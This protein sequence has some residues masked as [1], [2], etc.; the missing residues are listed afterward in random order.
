MLQ[1]VSIPL[2]GNSFGKGKKN[3]I[4]ELR[5][6]SF[7]PLTGKQF[8]KVLE[9]GTLMR[10]RNRFHPLTGKQFRK[11]VMQLNTLVQGFH[12]L[13]GKQFRKAVCLW[14]LGIETLFPSPY[15]EIVSESCPAVA[16][17]FFDIADCFHPLTGK[18]FRKESSE[19]ALRREGFKGQIDGTPYLS[20]E[21]LQQKGIFVASNPYPDWH[22]R[23]P[24]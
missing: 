9:K 17:T 10:K 14:F 23:E 5:L 4:C 2:R 8:R 15:G 11:V 22:R 3:Q 16:D 19:E 18:Q 6:Q 13:T 1:T 20:T 24:T 7:H 12:P 21:T